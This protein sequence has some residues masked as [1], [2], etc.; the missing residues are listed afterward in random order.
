MSEIRLV[1][2]LL[3]VCR[4]SGSIRA[5]PAP[6][7]GGGFFGVGISPAYGGYGDYYR[8]PGGYGSYN[9]RPYY[10]KYRYPHFY[11]PIAVLAG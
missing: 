8:Y 4:L 9:R 10:G 2:I 1:V 5:G 3:L 6:I 7:L 11:A